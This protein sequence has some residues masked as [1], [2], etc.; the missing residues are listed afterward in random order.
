MEVSPWEEDIPL[1]QEGHFGRVS[2]GTDVPT[3]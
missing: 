2:E 3:H 1:H